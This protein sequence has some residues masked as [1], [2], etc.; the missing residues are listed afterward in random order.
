MKT[1]KE[2]SETTSSVLTFTLQVSQKEKKEE[3]NVF[4]ETMSEDF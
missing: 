4:D 3:E 1:F 2:T